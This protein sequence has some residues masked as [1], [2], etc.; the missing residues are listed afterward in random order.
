M[1]N[2]LGIVIT[3]LA[4]IYFY[5]TCCSSCGTV[6]VEDNPKQVM[7]PQSEPEPTFYPFSLKDGDFTYETLDNFNFN[8][9]SSNYLT[10][11]SSK[12]EAGVNTE[13]KNYLSSNNDKVIN[14]T[15]YYKSDEINETAYP[16][17]GLAR[18]NS[19]KNYLVSQEI[20]S[21]KINIS[22]ELKDDFIP[23]DKVLMGPIELSLNEVSAN[24]EAEIK[25][26]YNKIKENPL[27]LYFDT[28][29]ASISL[30][31][32]QRQKVADIARYL[33][34]VPDAQ[35]E[36]IGYTDSEGK[37]STN[38]RLGQERA[39]FAKAYLVNN[40]IPEGRISTAS[41]GKQ[42]PIASNDTEEGR[43]QNRRT[44]ISIK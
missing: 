8:L 21:S 27:V 15:G 6:T 14:V 18:A 32:E 26:L 37:V 11:L 4:G 43:A 20:P 22:G 42:N 34:K 10:P 33:D 19:V 40:G 12:I 2:L 17:L 28:A 30:S 1:T 3:I 38:L 23:K 24:A 7:A 25:A 36:I 13:L 9:S 29:Q 44:V 41:K 35:S 39:D 5:I 16:N 31:T